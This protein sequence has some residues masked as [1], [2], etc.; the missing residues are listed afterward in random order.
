[1]FEANEK[2]SCRHRFPFTAKSGLIH[3]RHARI[4]ARVFGIR[5]DGPEVFG[6]PGG[7][8]KLRE[9]CRKNFHLVAPLITS[10]VTSYDRKNPK[11]LTTK[12]A[13]TTLM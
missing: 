9:A 5:K 13:T 8:R 3:G 4:L 12:K 2:R 7:F 10:V 1:M 11:R 6:G